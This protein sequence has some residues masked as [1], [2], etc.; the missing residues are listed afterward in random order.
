MKQVFY[1]APYDTT[2]PAGS[3]ALPASFFREFF[4]SDR[5]KGHSSPPMLH[6][7]RREARAYK[8]FTL[9]P[10]TAGLRRCEFSKRLRNPT[11][12]GFTCEK[13]RKKADS[14][15][16]TRHTNRICCKN[17]KNF[18]F[19]C[20]RD[21]KVFS[22]LFAPNRPGRRAAARMAKATV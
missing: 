14:G 19:P 17:E 3:Q 20:N 8:G 16:K 15:Q 5:K 13:H 22:W 10:L 7:R 1:F 11:V 6:A 9:C 4:A 21:C 18:A 12:Q 2:S